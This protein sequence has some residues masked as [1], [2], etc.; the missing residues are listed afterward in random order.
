VLTYCTHAGHSQQRD[1]KKSTHRAGKVNTGRNAIK[2]LD[3]KFDCGDRLNVV[4]VL[5][6]RGQDG[7]WRYPP[8]IGITRPARVTHAR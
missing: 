4:V 5:S 7:R 6:R 1:G 8:S 3:V 2:Y